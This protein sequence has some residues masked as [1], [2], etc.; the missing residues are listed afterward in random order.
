MLAGFAARVFQIEGM[1]LGNQTVVGE[2]VGHLQALR[3]LA[4][5]A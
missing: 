1:Y 4:A 5:R 3:L 2:M